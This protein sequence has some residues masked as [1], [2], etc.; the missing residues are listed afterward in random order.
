MLWHPD[1]NLFFLSMAKSQ[2]DFR[3]PHNRDALKKDLEELG[4][5]D[6]ELRALFNDAPTCEEN[7]LEVYLSVRGRASSCLR[8]YIEI[9]RTYRNVKVPKRGKA[10]SSQLEYFRTELVKHKSS[11]SYWWSLVERRIHDLRVSLHVTK[12]ETVQALDRQVQSLIGSD[13][14][15][16]SR[17]SSLAD[18]P[19]RSQ[20]EDAF[21]NAQQKNLCD[22]LK[23]TLTRLDA[24]FPFLQQSSTSL[25]KTEQ[26][27]HTYNRHLGTSASLLAAVKRRSKNNTSFVWRAFY[28]FAGICGFIFLKRF[29]IFK[30]TISITS[31]V[32]PILSR[33]AVGTAKTI[34]HSTLDSIHIEVLKVFCGIKRATFKCID[35]RLGHVVLWNCCVASY[36]VMWAFYP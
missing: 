8:A 7:N 11:M 15:N 2:I 5:L 32:L 17:A 23:G 12:Y 19:K 10:L 22:I 13:P 34:S 33:T 31:Y 21:A 20:N 30:T 35:L 36:T 14:F 1:D 4:K 9:L 29:R 16:R 6:G 18:T 25:E 27:Y 28:I 24:L 3:S 26:T